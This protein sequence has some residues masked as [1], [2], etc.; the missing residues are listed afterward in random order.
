MRDI[1]IA[2]IKGNTEISI[3]SKDGYN[4]IYDLKSY[5]SKVINLEIV[6]CYAI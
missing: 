2:I 1:S 6:N 3:P 4:I 5:T